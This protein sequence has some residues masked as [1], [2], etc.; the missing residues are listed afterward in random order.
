MVRMSEVGAR[1]IRTGG[2]GGAGYLVIEAVEAF[3][4]YDFSE[5]Q[6]TVTLLI[7]TAVFA[8]IQSFVEN[9][10]GKGFLRQI[11]PTTV[12]VPGL[13]DDS[14]NGT[15][16]GLEDVPQ[17]TQTDNGPRDVD[18]PEDEQPL[19]DPNYIPPSDDE[20]DDFEE[21]DLEVRP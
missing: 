3:N 8:V 18:P 20:A 6:S 17:P 14:V 19:Q 21:S 11:P 15:E 1:G 5:R 7:L 2:Q 10:I 9:K 12:P 13:S 16:D 4:V